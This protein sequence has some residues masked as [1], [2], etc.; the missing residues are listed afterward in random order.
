M[1]LSFKS[2]LIKDMAWKIF[3]NELKTRNG[4]LNFGAMS[5]MIIIAL[6]FSVFNIDITLLPILIPLLIFAIYPISIIGCGCFVS[7]IQ[8]F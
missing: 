1:E 7:A 3:T 5:V 6:L 2:N 4:K 8:N